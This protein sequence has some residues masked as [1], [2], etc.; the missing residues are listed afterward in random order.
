MDLFFYYS[1]PD[2]QAGGGWEKD[3]VKRDSDYTVFRLRARG[4][5]RELW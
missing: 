1:P 2:Q 4:A 5:V 3:A